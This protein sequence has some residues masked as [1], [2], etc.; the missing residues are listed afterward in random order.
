MKAIIFK[1]LSNTALKEEYRK[2]YPDIVK[3]YRTDTFWSSSTNIDNGKLYEYVYSVEEEK[4]NGKNIEGEGFFNLY[5]TPISQHIKV[6]FIDGNINE[7]DFYLK[8]VKLGFLIVDEKNDNKILETV[9]THSITVENDVVNIVNI[10]KSDRRD[11][12]LKKI[13]EMK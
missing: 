2:D 1:E 12:N 7:Y 9:Y 3:L 5:I 4:V 11:K 6:L 8:G 13:L 10:V